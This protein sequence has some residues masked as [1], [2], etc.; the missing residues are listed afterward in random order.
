MRPARFV[1][2]S[3]NANSPPTSFKIPRIPTTSLETIHLPPDPRVRPTQCSR[4]RCSLLPQQIAPPRR[5]RRRWTHQA[6]Y[7]PSLQTGDWLQ[8]RSGRTQRCAKQIKQGW[9]RSDEPGAFRKKPENLRWGSTWWALSVWGGCCLPGWVLLG[10]RT[11]NGNWPVFKK[12][13]LTKSNSKAGIWRHWKIQ[14][15][16][17]PPRRGCLYQSFLSR[18]R[19]T[20]APERCINLKTQQVAPQSGHG[21][22]TSSLFRPMAAPA[23][24]CDWSARFPRFNSA[25]Y[26][27]SYKGVKGG[28]GEKNH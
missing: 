11:E 13:Q 24:R 12:T 25:Y 10:R 4:A 5:G 17:S 16:L 22:L 26:H 21:K 23:K 1:L 14:E 19:Q 15:K 2:K 9:V 8:I 28:G 3:C 20:R 7:P 27:T 6:A 18:S